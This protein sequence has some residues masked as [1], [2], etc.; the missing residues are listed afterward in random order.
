[1]YPLPQHRRNWST[2]YQKAKR[3]DSMEVHLHERETV[4]IPRPH[5]PALK[6]VL[7]HG[8]N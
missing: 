8:T 4:H 6:P 7:R 3:T 1:M 2:Q 5:L